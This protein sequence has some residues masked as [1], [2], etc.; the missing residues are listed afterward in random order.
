MPRGERVRWVFGSQ[1]AEYVPICLPAFSPANC[2]RE[3]GRV[4]PPAHWAFDGPGPMWAQAHVDILD[5]L[6][7]YVVHVFL[8]VF[9]M[10]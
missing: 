8:Y 9:Y 1:G 5:I 4:S 10:I 6:F 2:F 7:L 3:E